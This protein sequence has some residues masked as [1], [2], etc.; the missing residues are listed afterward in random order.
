MPLRAAGA[1][2][3][4]PARAPEQVGERD[5]ADR[6][7]ERG[8]R[9]QGQARAGHDHDGGTEPGPGGDA[10][11]VRVGQRVAEDALVGGAAAGQ[12]RADED[13]EHDPGQ[14]DLPD[15]RRVE[16]GNRDVRM[17][18]QVGRDRLE[19][20]RHRQ[21]GR[22]DGHPDDD[23]DDSSAAVADRDRPA[24]PDPAGPGRRPAASRFGRTVRPILRSACTGAGTGRPA[25]APGSGPVAGRLPGA[26]APGRAT[27]RWPRRWVSLSRDSGLD[28]GCDRLQQVHDPRPP[29]RGDVGV[30]H[31]DVLVLDCRQHGPAGPALTVAASWPPPVL[32]VSDR[33]M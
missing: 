1:S 17:P 15:D 5:R 20:L 28:A 8:R 19:H 3:P 2:P 23:G 29:A 18:G 31:D 14:P 11:Q 30:E 33:M 6:A 16:R 21:A 9:R 7:G 4:R 12:H 32:P 27:W 13:A 25:P 26:A 10:E 22:P 24:R